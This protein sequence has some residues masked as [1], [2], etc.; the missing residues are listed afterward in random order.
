MAVH[1]VKNLQNEVVEE[2]E[3]D[4]RLFGV[5]VKTHVL[6]DI[7]KNQL[8]KR[9]QGT[10]CT[11]TRSD[12]KGS[13]AKPYRQ[14][15]TGQARAG[16]KK[17]PIWRSGGVAFGPKPRDYGYSLP[18]KV[19]RLG[20]RMALSARCGEG[21]LTVVDT[22]SMDEIKTKK[23]VEIMN[24]LEMNNCLVV[25]DRDNINVKKSARN[26]VG[27]KVLPSEGLNVFDILKYQKLLLDKDS[28]ARL[29]KR[30]LA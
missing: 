18:K 9:R 15:G 21:N 2:I 1:N 29:E 30:L 10:A 5:E 16:S 22:F 4:D 20:L 8:A 12:V 6:H 19:R 14:K 7:I 13:G 24:R 11:K 23:F 3:L 27:F 26:V 25:T 28:I 17:S